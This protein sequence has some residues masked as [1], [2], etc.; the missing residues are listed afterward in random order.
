MG[1]KPRL[2]VAAVPMPKA[3]PDDRSD[4]VGVI[5]KYAYFTDESLPQIKSGDQ[6][7]Q[8]SSGHRIAVDVLSV[9][10]GLISTHVK[11]YVML[12]R[13]K[14][15]RSSQGDSSKNNPRPGGRGW[16][17][18]NFPHQKLSALFRIS[19]FQYPGFCPILGFASVSASGMGW[20]RRKLSVVIV[21]ADAGC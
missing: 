13:H 18:L 20:M 19:H 10:E 2:E 7:G 21:C 12:V 16:S 14:H 1:L 8:D 9:V 11:P 4:G 5:K 6:T 15:W 3:R 17:S